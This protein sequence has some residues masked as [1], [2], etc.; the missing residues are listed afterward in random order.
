[1]SEVDEIRAR[2][3]AERAEQG[4]P[5]SIEAPEA[6]S[7]AA[8]LLLASPADRSLLAGGRRAAHASA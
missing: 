6:V 1:M 5:A 7:A 3:A 8:A 2:V 4:L